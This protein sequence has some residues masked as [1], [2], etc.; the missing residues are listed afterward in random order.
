MKKK[1]FDFFSDE[2]LLEMAHGYKNLPDL[3]EI[4]EISRRINKF[5]TKNKYF[6]Q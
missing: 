2:M 6:N 4:K 1:G 3:E 5:I